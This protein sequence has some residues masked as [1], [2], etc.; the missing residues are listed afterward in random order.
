MVSR[1]S[2]HTTNFIRQLFDAERFGNVRQVV[3]FQK[4]TRLRGDKIAGD[5]KKAL[6]QWIAE[7]FQGFAAV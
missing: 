1:D 4:L 2:Q 7:A 3:A 5:K 6:A